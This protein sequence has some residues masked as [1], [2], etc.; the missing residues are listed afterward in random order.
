M[1]QPT[2]SNL[3]K[4]IAGSLVARGADTSAK[5][6]SIESELEEIL[7]YL[8]F[9]QEW[10]AMD[11]K[12]HKPK[13]EHEKDCGV[14]VKSR[15]LMRATIQQIKALYRKEVEEAIEQSK[16]DGMFIEWNGLNLVDADEL[17]AKLLPPTK[18][19]NDE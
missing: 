17:R 12:D 7:D 9:E 4:G 2:N 8:R 13:T 6:N 10:I 11:A 18:G 16:V 1:T 15:V 5:D 19:G 14:C 3:Q